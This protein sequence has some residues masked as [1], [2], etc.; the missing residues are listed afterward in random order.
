MNLFSRLFGST[1]P[2]LPSIDHPIFGL[3]QACIKI[4]EDTYFWEMPENVETEYGH[5]S[6][7]CDAPITGPTDKQIEQFHMICDQ[8][9]DLQKQVKPLLRERLDGFNAGDQID[10][11]NWIAIALANDGEMKS[12]WELSFEDPNNF[13]IY[14][15]NFNAGTP[16]FVTVDS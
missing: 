14:N 6:V 8:F 4:D 13:Y 11:L 16:E 7:S 2:N 5:I 12:H 15:V 10:N 9:P 3:M 1:K